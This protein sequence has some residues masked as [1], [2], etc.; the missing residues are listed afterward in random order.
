MNTSRF[1]GP[2]RQNAKL[3][4]GLQAL[5]GANPAV[6]VALGGLVGSQ[7]AT[8]PDQAT[9]P[10]S[11]F[12]LGLALGILPAAFFMRKLGRRNA[13]IIGSLL[14]IGG[15]FVAFMGVTQSSF[16]IFCLGTILAGFYSSYVQN[17]RFAAADSVEAQWRPKVIAWVMLGGLVAAVL[18]TQII[19]HTR[20][21]WPDTP[22]AATFIAQAGLAALALPFIFF[23]RDE[24]M[25]PSTVVSSHHNQPARPLLQI[26]KN[27]R[28]LIAVLTGMVSYSLMS[29]MMTASPL[30]MVN[31]GHSVEDSTLG[32]Q[33]HI[34]AMFAPSFF[35][36]KLIERFGKIPITLSGIALFAGASLAALSG[37]EVMHFWLSL[38]LLGVGWNFSFI[39]ATTLVTD[40]YQPA[41]TSK[42]QAFNDFLIFGTVAL[43]SFSSGK[44]LAH[45]GWSQLNL[46]SFPVIGV[47]SLALLWHGYLDLRKPVL[48]SPQP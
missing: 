3:L 23:L 43:S 32:V 27:P 41:E 38:I 30:A 37:L 5:G 19:L 15:G 11:L 44:L 33:W 24:L 16:L 34:L 17:Y 12:N 48:R 42:V 4:V 28:F 2:R 29:F 9:L 39:G 1:S 46:W 35:T 20:N 14:G 13:Y 31:A 40:C 47:V 26:L 21:L 10:V 6:V 18:A 7:L 36:S 45:Y 22:F 25:S 8:H